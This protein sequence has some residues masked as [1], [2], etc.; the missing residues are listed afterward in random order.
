[1]DGRQYVAERAAPGSYD[2]I[3]QDAVNDLSVPAHVDDR[4]RI[5]QALIDRLEADCDRFNADLPELRSFVLPG[6]LSELLAHVDGLPYD[7]GTS[8]APLQFTRDCAYHVLFSDGLANLDQGLPAAFASPVYAVAGDAQANHP[9]LREIAQR[10]GGAYLNLQRVE[11][12]VALATLGAPVFAFL[13]ASGAGTTTTQLGRC[14]RHRKKQQHRR[15]HRRPRAGP[16]RRLRW[17]DPSVR[18]RPGRVRCDQPL[19][20]RAVCL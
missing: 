4:L 14:L 8:M 7:G 11:D 6:G 1:M 5:E 9:L 17:R 19:E 20:I 18:R 12:D 10:S 2:L 15:A 3:I 13:G 16:R